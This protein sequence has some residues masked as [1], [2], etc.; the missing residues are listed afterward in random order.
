[1]DLVLATRNRAKFA[2]IVEILRGLPAVLISLEESGFQDVVEETGQSYMENA[3]LKALSVAAATGRVTLAEDSGLEVEA[4]GGHP[5]GGHPPSGYPGVRSAR[6]GG[7]GLDDI[8]R[9]A[10]LLRRL[11]SVPEEGRRARF[12]CVVALADPAGEVRFCQGSC[13]GVI[14]REARGNS[15][16]GYDP[17]FLVPALGK[18]FAELPGKVKNTI[19]HRGRAL[20]KARA[21]LERVCREGTFPQIKGGSE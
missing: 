17:V 15:G 5:P 19:S 9:V 8:A 21:L 1:M 6:F 12:I 4:L 2:E 7:P 10:L 20:Q 13:E 14:A 18:T 11:E 3:A 16:F